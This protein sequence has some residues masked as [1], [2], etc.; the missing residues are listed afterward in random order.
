[1]AQRIEHMGLFKQQRDWYGSNLYRYF[2]SVDD[3][4]NDRAA[5]LAYTVANGLRVGK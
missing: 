3:R 5:Y 2:P 4:I 1:M